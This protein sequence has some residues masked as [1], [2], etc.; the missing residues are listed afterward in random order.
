MHAFF[1]HVGASVKQQLAYRFA[2]WAG[3]FT[4]TFFLVFR[5]YA[6]RACYHGRDE[7][8]G[9]D[10]RGVVAYVAVSQALL[11]VIPQWGRIG[12]A[13]SVRTGQIATELCRPIDLLSQL[14]AVRAGVSAYYS[15][16]RMAPLMLLSA[17]AGFVSLPPRPLDAV[18]FLISV[19]LGAWIANLILVLIEASSFWLG[20]ER[21]V[22]YLVM[23]ISSLVSGLILP[24]SFLPDTVQQLSRWLPFES[25]LYWA[26]RV[27]LGAPPAS[28]ASGLLGQAAWALLLTALAR[29]VLA[30]G[31]RRLVIH[32]G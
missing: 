24:I 27:Y 22:R 28:L 2:N 31:T 3:I 7:I 29:S 9:L 6:L 17:L 15:F 1:A 20:T 26:T 14:L 19:L 18:G 25:T 4:N 8:G 10:A 30:L 21:G 32:G 5:A 23:G 12:L 13:A 11:M 16:A